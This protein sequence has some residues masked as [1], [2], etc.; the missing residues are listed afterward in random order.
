MT[1]F[2]LDIP[3]MSGKQLALLRELVPQLSRLGHS[4]Q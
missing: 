1:G 3:E 2:F 4:E